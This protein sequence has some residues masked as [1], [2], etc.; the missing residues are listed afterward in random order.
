MKR[1][2]VPAVP[3]AA[4][5]VRV[6][7]VVRAVAVASVRVA[8]AVVVVVAAAVVVAGKAPL[9][10]LM[11][12]PLRRAFLFGFLVPGRRFAVVCESLDNCRP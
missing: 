4:V 2:I 11:K 12:G 5:A 9:S 6:A 10:L 1:R 7:A 8:A 3:A